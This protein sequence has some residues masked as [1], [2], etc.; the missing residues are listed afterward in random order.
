MT[1]DIP[2][3]QQSF[4]DRVKYKLEWHSMTQS[5]LAVKIGVSDKHVSML[6]SGRSQG[7][8]NIWS[9]IFDVLNIDI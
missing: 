4:I 6:L 1:D 3:I 7:T 8:L 2:W 9:N 5:E